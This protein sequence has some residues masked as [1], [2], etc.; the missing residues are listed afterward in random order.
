MAG[1]TFHSK[2]ALL[3]TGVEKSV[4]LPPALPQNSIPPMLSQYLARVTIYLYGWADSRSSGK[5]SGKRVSPSQPH[6]V[7]DSY[8]VQAAQVRDF[9]LKR[10]L[11]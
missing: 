1:K 7:L 2:V 10:S 3:D 6:D 4:H 5:T 9:S 11:S 8:L